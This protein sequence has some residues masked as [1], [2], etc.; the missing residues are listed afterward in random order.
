MYWL[1]K[2]IWPLTMTEEKCNTKYVHEAMQG[3]NSE[4]T[5]QVCTSSKHAVRCY[6]SSSI[7]IPTKPT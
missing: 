4:T 3:Y 5:K 7:I 1:A 2:G 6:L